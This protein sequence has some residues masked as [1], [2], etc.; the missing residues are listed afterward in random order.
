M[1]IL[2][3]SNAIPY[4]T[5]S[6]SKVRSYNLLRRVAKKHEVWFATLTDGA[7][8]AE[9]LSHIGQIC[10]GVE[11]VALRRRHLLMHVPGLLRYALAGNPLEL[12][13]VHYEEL[14]RKIQR[15]FTTTD[16]DIVQIEPSQMALY[17]ETLP[18]DAGFKSLLMFHNVAYNQYYHIFRFAPRLV[19]RMRAL[20]HSLMMRRWEP[21]YAERFDRCIT[22][23]EEDRR[24]LLAV[25][26]RLQV[27]VIPNGV[28][29]SIYHVQPKEYRTPDLLFVGNLGYTACSD[30]AT[31]FCREILPIV[32]RVMSDVEMWIVG[33]NPPP[34]VTRLQGDGVHITGRVDSVLP[35]YRQSSVC[36]VPLRIGG[37][38]RLKILEA[39][40]MG[41]PVVSTSVGAEG[42]DVV[43]DEHILIADTPDEFARK[44]VLLL[45]NARLSDRIAASARQLVEAHYDWDVIAQRLMRAYAQMVD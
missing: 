17:I 23:S 42:L 11:T 38:S 27:D 36:V 4:P 28:D 20:L 24:L 9:G 6:G 35:Y 19:S 10:S 31:Y 15:L 34:E 8:E 40:A 2:I 21:R 41:R 26:P 33:T 5:D 45:Q 14:V 30:A 3:I 12:K 44:I 1:R 29:T 25:D 39:M 16:F 37:G 22:V 13:F 7:E 43:A 18:T 32:R